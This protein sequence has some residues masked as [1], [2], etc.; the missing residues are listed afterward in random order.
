MAFDPSSPW[1]DPTWRPSGLNDPALTAYY[2]QELNAGNQFNDYLKNYYN[3]TNAYRQGTYSD[4]RQPL[5]QLLVPINGQFAFGSGP[6]PLN[7]DG[8]FN[9]DILN[10][11]IKDQ[12]SLYQRDLANAAQNKDDGILGGGLYKLANIVAIAGLGAG[13]GSAFSGAGAS[14]AGTEAAGTAASSVPSAAGAAGA[15][16][17]SLDALAAG[18]NYGGISAIPGTAA[19]GGFSTAGG[20]SATGALGALP[21]GGGGM[22]F[23]DNGF[24]G[25]TG[26]ALGNNIANGATRGAI[27]SGIS[28]GNPIQGAATGGI[29]GGLNGFF[30]NSSGFF[31]GSGMDT[32]G[33]TSGFNWGGLIGSLAGPLLGA[34]LGGSS[35]GNQQAG[36]TTTTNEPWAAQKPYLLNAFNNANNWYSHGGTQIAP[37]N[38]FQ[39]QSFNLAQGNINNPTLSAAGNSIT[40]F[41]NGNMMNNPWL[42]QMA[43]AADNSITRNYQ[44]VV[45]PGISSGF[46]ANGR[47]GSGAMANAQSQAQQDL[48]HQLGYTNANIY[49]NAY[50]QGLNNMLQASSL[51]PSFNASQL[52]NIGALNSAGNQVQAQQQSINQQPLT[53]LQNYQNIV[54]G[55]LYGSQVSQPYFQNKTANILGGGLLGAQ[56]APAITNAISPWFSNTSSSSTP[57]DM[58]GFSAGGGWGGVGGFYGNGF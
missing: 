54:G 38:P 45:S 47:Y 55:Q 23:G 41:A 20:L 34:A 58:T 42:S 56:L 2:N 1:T 50:Q 27:T 3:S 21:A 17:G 22:F 9:P 40:N 31:G 49:G 36:T 30:G 6:P 37:L 57:A 11:A 13:L 32:S 26:S 10:G 16:P 12:Y 33:D 14:G 15:A 46:E 44:N 19:T 29:S 7:P 8:T 28:G 4:P 48:A 39:M 51:A 52:S 18:A 24:F 5:G 25:N 43:D 35:S 53:N